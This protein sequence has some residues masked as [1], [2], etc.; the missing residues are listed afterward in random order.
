MKRIPVWLLPFGLAVTQ[1]AVWPGIPPA[2]DDPV[3][4]V[5]VATGVTATVVVAVALLWRRSAP[6]VTITI[7]AVALTVGTYGVPTDALLAISI[8]DLIALYSVAVLRPDRIALGI[9][10]AV[11]LWQCALVATT[12]G[13]DPDYPAEV[14]TILVVYS[15]V[16]AF[17][18]A[19]HR[20]R[21]DRRT[22]AA[23]LAEAEE[24]RARAADTERHR[25]ARELHDVTAHHLTSI[26][27]IA[28]AA[29]RLGGSRPEL[30]AEARE[31]AARTGRDT[32]VALHR[33]VALLRLPDERPGLLAARLAELAE[34]FRLLGQPVSVRI[35]HV[36]DLSAATVEAV[37]GITRE[38]LTNTLRYAPG[39]G[40]RIRLTGGLELTI[41]DDGPRA[42]GAGSLGS[43]RGI[44][45]MRERATALGGTLTAGPRPGGGWRVR[46]V[47]PRA[48]TAVPAPRRRPGSEHVI[49]L[50][51]FPLALFP[52]VAGLLLAGDDPDLA[53]A[54]VPLLVLVASAHAVP[55]IW[56]R[57]HPW[58]VL[59][60]VA[61]TAWALPAL[62]A[63]GV[64]PP[65]QG[66][67][68]LA[69]LG[70]ETVAV[71]AV[72]RYAHPGDLTALAI[73]VAFCSAV[74]ATAVTLT[75]D[76][77]PE[78]GRTRS[79]PP[80]CTRSG[81]P[82]SNG[83]GWRPGCARRSC[84]T[85]PRWRPPRTRATWIRCWARRG[86]PST[87]CAACST[88]CATSRARPAIPS[89]PRRRCPAWW[90]A[91]AV[92]GVRWGWS[93]TP[94]DGCCRR[95]WICRRSGWWS[96]CWP[97]TP[98]R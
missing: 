89:R 97:G 93:C 23:R 34:G 26:V 24:R 1:L 12:S 90:T 50:A 35:D 30:V 18:R 39:G 40:V 60:A 55:V 38:A 74:L 72:A 59:G 91:G 56:R 80:H 96:C 5:A 42:E 29:Q 49:D 15:T 14:A 6:L 8:A 81:R 71:Y 65:A 45:G 41:D 43:G 2:G 51:L 87:R 76:P 73:P 20:W 3:P 63:T 77:P 94:R 22:A 64:V 82:A 57:S 58:K 68:L 78:E 84:A 31:F 75:L 69:G 27:V 52:P 98:G 54:P 28:S 83:P 92:A 88:A 70:A 95:M 11:M 46:A 4:A 7:V 32:L 79:P 53:V 33:L 36:G 47:L 25:L 67:M 13:A 37:C 16:V 61:A 62:I 19:R 10:A 66:W 86:R 48:D 85:P 9:A 44:D 21:T 17:G